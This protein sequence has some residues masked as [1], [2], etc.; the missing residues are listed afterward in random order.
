[1]AGGGRATMLEESG[2]PSDGSTELP[3]QPGPHPLG[4]LHEREESTSFSS[5]IGFVGPFGSLGW[6]LLFIDTGMFTG[7]LLSSLSPSQSELKSKRGNSS[8]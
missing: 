8:C 1:M 2:S 3:H 4:L 6:Y 5:S 7:S